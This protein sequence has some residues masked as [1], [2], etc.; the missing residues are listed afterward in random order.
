MQCITWEEGCELLAEV[1]EVSA[2]TIHVPA[3]WL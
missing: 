2:G 1:M 3:R